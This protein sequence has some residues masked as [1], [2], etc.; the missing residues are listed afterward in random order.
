MSNGGYN[1]GN[2]G[3]KL[4]L[5]G[6][7]V[8]LTPDDSRSRETYIDFVGSIFQVPG[9]DGYLTVVHPDDETWQFAAQAYP[10]R[11]A[12]PFATRKEAERDAEARIRQIH[13]RIQRD[14]SGRS[15]KYEKPVEKKK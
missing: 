3:G 6:E 14:V 13:E 2:G 5:P 11:V 10:E 7:P 9:F 8:L 4:Y 12:G 15:Q 1:N